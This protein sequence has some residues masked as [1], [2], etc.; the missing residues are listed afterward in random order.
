M[1]KSYLTAGLIALG[2]AAWILTGQIGGGNDDAA[3]SATAAPSPGAPPLVKVRVRTLD[4]V[5]HSSDVVLR[6]R[7]QALRSVD[8]KAQTDGRIVALPVEKGA[9]VKA[10]ELICRLAVDDRKARLAEAQA[11]VRQRQIEYDAAVQL[12]AKG[13]R[14]ENQ[15][16]AARALLDGARAQVKQMQVELEHTRILAPFAGTV[17]DRPVEIGDYLQK[18]QTCATIVDEDP[19]LVVGEVS[20]R[21]VGDLNIGDVGEVR[22]LDGKTLEGKVRF[23]AKTADPL[24]R[25]FRV[26]L[27]VANPDHSLRDGM[28]AEIR[29]T[30]REILAHR[31]SPALLVLDAK[32]RMGIRIVDGKGIVRFQPV[33]I[34]SDEPEG[35]WVTGLPARVTV[36]TVGQEFVRA[37]QKVEVHPDNGATT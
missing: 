29:I 25:T 26:E 32:G 5:P 8:L 1:K 22:L 15:V 19:F 17:D 24:T 21:H 37:G 7:T 6:G 34:V 33:T 36:I 13:Y 16:A 28:T 2:V 4:A 31:I 3:D 14:A 27:E 9:Q 20:E 11:L 12:A 10:G 23:I 30:A 35:M 18:G